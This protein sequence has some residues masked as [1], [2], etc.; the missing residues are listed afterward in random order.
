[1]TWRD[2]CKGFAVQRRM[3][4]RGECDQDGNCLYLVCNYERIPIR[5]VKKPEEVPEGW[6]PSGTVEWVESVLGRTVV[7]DYFPTFATNWIKRRIWYETKW[8]LRKVF[9]KP[10]DRHKRF[11]G[12]VTSGRYRKKKRG[13]YVCSDIVTF[14]DEWRY[15]VVYGKLIG[16]YW[17]AGIGDEEKPAPEID[18]QYPAD[19]C[20]TADFGRLTSGEIALVECHPPFACGWYGKK[21]E[22]YAE[23]LTLGWKW[24]KEQGSM[25]DEQKT[26]IRDG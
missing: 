12:F 3:L 6:T 22:E 19:W 10:A 21:H 9:I 5:I 8:P 11:N 1:M 16:G 24:L 23:F 18:I 13:P 15:Y 17:Y 26:P 14:Q 2:H 7:P 25:L 20:G 4:G